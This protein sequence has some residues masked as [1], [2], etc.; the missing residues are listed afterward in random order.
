M[1]VDGL[2][3][4]KIIMIIDSTNCLCYNDAG[5]GDEEENDS[6]DSPKSLV[7]CS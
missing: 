6:S 1:N 7:L 2:S 4:T 5:Q 3:K